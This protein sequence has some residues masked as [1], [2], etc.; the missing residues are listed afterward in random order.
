[1]IPVV[2]VLIVLDTTAASY[3]AA[4]VFVI[5]GMTDYLDGF[6]ARRFSSSTVTGQWLDPLSDK[7]FV[8]APVLTMASLDRFPVWGAAVI[9][10]R[11]VAVSVLRVYLGTRRTSLPASEVAKWKTFAQLVAI[12]LY[13]LPLGSGSDALRLTFLVIAVA[14]TIYSGLDYFL[15]LSLRSQPR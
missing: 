14:V 1:L 11:E 10:A 13:L 9:V 12:T 7:L 2:V 8:A 4:A 6:L 3:A 15:R 5:G